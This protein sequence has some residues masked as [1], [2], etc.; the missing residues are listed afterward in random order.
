MLLRSSPLTTLADDPPS[1]TPSVSVSRFT[2]LQQRASN[3]ARR[4]S[5]PT[6]LP[7]PFT[8]AFPGPPRTPLLSLGSP[9][10]LSGAPRVDEEFPLSP[11]PAAAVASGRVEAIA[12]ALLRLGCCCS[13][14]CLCSPSS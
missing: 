14:V 7:L 8:L 5:A 9:P 10:R 2:G 13:I 12:A 3:P 1:L 4:A 11:L 6:A